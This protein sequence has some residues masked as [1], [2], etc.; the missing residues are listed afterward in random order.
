MTQEN[1]DVKFKRTNQIIDRSGFILKTLI[2]NQQEKIDESR[3]RLYIALLVGNNI[4][5][6]IMDLSTIDEQVFLVQCNNHI[7]KRGFSIFW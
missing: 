4:S 5:Y 7:G 3:V 6:T 1:I 2:S